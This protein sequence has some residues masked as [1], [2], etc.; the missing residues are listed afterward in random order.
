MSIVRFAFLA[1]LCLLA[2]C[3]KSSDTADEAK[4]S[5]LLELTQKT[6]AADQ[7]ATLAPVLE[8]R[9][10]RLVTT[11]RVPAQLSARRAVAAIYRSQDGA[12]GGVVY[13]QRANNTTE[14]IT[15]HWYF[16]DGAPDSLQLVELNGDGLWDAR[17]FM[18]GG[19][20]RDFIQG[21]TFTLMTDR[22]ARFAMN[23]ASSGTDAWKAFDGDTTTAWQS[24]AKGAFVEIPLPIGLEAGTLSL[25]VAG[26]GHVGKVA[27]YA[28]DK[29]VQDVDLK[30]TGTL[31]DVPLDAAV[32]EAPAIRVV[33]EGRDATVAISELEIR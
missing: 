11:Q 20:T 19:T 28:G 13:M 1:C 8:A 18:A 25:R 16:A 3:S 22:E 23:G 21:E 9:G 33:V 14:G 4:K 26:G 7:A 15:W 17:V 2:G 6:A 24:P 29:K 12:R 32:K 10:F 30:D 31:R 5:P 27:I